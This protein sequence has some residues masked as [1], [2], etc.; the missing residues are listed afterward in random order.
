[1]EP[2]VRT[3]ALTGFSGLCRAWRI[4]AE[5]LLARVGLDPRLLLE[6]DHWIPAHAAARLL[7]LSATASSREDFGLLLSD[8]RRLSTLGPICLALRQEPDL[9]SV[10][11]TL[12]RHQSMY[13]EALRG[14][15]T[16]SAGLATLSVDMRIDAARPMNGATTPQ[17]SGGAPRWRPT[18]STL[19]GRIEAASAFFSRFVHGL[20]HR[21]GAR[22]ELSPA[23]ACLVPRRPVAS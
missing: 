17:L 8:Q 10:I 18:P 20:Q 14:G 6:Q 11:T 13:N 19:P 3:A 23:P 1:M 16:D 22:G 9:R 7:D 15:L 12:I 2:F 5:P 4:E 21:D